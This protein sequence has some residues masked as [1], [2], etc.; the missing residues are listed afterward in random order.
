MVLPRIEPVQIAVDDRVVESATSAGAC[1]S[2]YV[3]VVQASIADAAAPV[4]VQS[5]ARR[6]AA[7]CAL[8]STVRRRTSGGAW[9]EVR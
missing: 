8:A 1:G 7:S 4:S 5:V 3:F 9:Q 6:G 2:P